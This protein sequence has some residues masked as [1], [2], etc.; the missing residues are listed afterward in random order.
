MSLC[1][2]VQ[3]P[4]QIYLL[5]LETGF[6]NGTWRSEHPTVPRTHSGISVSLYWQEPW[7]HVKKIICAPSYLLVILVICQGMHLPTPSLYECFLMLSNQVGFNAPK[8]A[9]TTCTNSCIW[10]VTSALLYVVTIPGNCGV[11]LL[12][13]PCFLSSSAHRFHTLKWKQE[14]AF[15]CCF[16]IGWRSCCSQ[17]EM[18]VGY[19]V[20]FPLLSDIW[21]KLSSTILYS[22][23]PEILCNFI[24]SIATNWNWE[25]MKAA[26]HC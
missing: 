13:G 22:F 7:L 14:C 18:Q 1:Q 19:V 8:E 24:L 3:L 4:R 21:Q 11:Y 17:K 10:T 16:A 2:F 15:S 25:L 12:T 20:Y 6:R 5:T 26:S 23:L 9:V